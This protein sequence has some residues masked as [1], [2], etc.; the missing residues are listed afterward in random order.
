[1]NT[2]SL[3]AVSQLSQVLEVGLYRIN[4]FKILGIEEREL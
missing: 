2:W 4:N 1:M 3:T